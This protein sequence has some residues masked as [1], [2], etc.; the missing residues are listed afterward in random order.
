MS[1]TPDT[2]LI[3]PD[4][5]TAA[6][7]AQINRLAWPVMAEMLLQTMAQ[8]VSMILVGRLGATAVTSIGLSMQPLNMLYGVF[9]GI[10]VAATALVAR[11][12]GAGRP[13]FAA[14]A[15]AQ[16]MT[17]SGLIAAAGAAF[18][19]VKA[20]ALVLWM[21]AGPEVVGDGTRY[22]L[23]MTPGL[24]FMWIQSVLN[25]ALRGAGD[26][27]TPMKVNI[28]VS[29]LN[30]L[31]NLVLVYGLLGLPA[32]GVLGAGLAT[33]I[34]RTAGGVTLLVPYVTGHLTLP[35]R[36]PDDFRWDRPLMKRVLNIAVPSAGERMLMSGSS[37]FYSRMVAGLGSV[38]YAAHTIGINAESISYMPGQAYAVA[39]TTLVGQNMGARRPDLAEKST[40]Q[41]LYMACALVGSVGLVFLLFPE[42]LMRLYTGDAE[43][44]RL[45]AIYLRI[46]AFCQIHQAFGY[47]FMGAIRGAG[48]PKLVMWVTAFSSWPVR[49]GTT[50]ILLNVVGTGVVG[51]WWG[52]AADGLFRGLA[53]WL[54]FRTGKWKEARA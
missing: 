13:D 2:G 53:S 3:A 5:E 21:G 17:L 49:L 38:A 34:A 12:I 37:L 52:M 45:G 51:A 23:I 39:A 42:N 29:I 11:S 6:I 16:S 27:R 48:H 25:G 4:T 54:W 18:I 46:M 28:M 40:Y 1:K 35:A 43:V 15:A 22:L 14:R 10:S 20:R 26:T 33:S 8:I 31:G 47:V 44:V 36:F 50:Y 19:L 32:M 9:M 41:S 30:F 24:F 7:R